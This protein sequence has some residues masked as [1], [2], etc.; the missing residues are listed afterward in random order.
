MQYVEEMIGINDGP[1]PIKL[2]VSPGSTKR[3]ENGFHKILGRNKVLF[4]QIGKLTE[5]VT[6][7]VKVIVCNPVRE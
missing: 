1:N 6:D 2:V 4:Q 5:G 3:E 7:P